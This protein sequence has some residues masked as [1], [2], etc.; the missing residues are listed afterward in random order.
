MN[1]LKVFTNE[2]FGD[3]A[4]ISIDN[5]PYFE[6]I[7]VARILG[8]KNPNDAIKRHC[9]YP[10]IVFHD[11]RVQTGRRRD[12]T[13]SFQ[14]VQRAFISE[15]NLYRLIVKS[16]KEEAE[17]FESWVMDEVLPSIRN[18]GGYVNDANYMIINEVQAENYIYYKLK[19]GNKLLGCIICSNNSEGY[20]QDDL[21]ILELI[22]KQIVLGMQLYKYNQ[23]E[24]KH[25][26]IAN[27]L[28]I[29]NKQQK[30]IMNESEMNLE[31]NK[32]LYF[33]HRCATVIGGDFYHAQPID[34][35]KV[36]YIIADVMGHGIVS[37]YIVAMIKGCFKTLCYNYQ[38]AADIM[39]KLNQI[40]YDE[41]DKMD[42]FTT[43]IVSIVDTQ[44]NTLDISNAG[45]YCPIIIDDTGNIS[46]ENN[47]CKKNIP[48]GV[49]EDTKYEHSTISIKS[50]AMICMYTDGI[51]EL[52]NQHKEEFGIERLEQFLLKNYKL[53]KDDFIA[54]LKKELNE[55]AAKHNFDDDILVVC[56]SN[57]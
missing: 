55:F 12:G 3:V 43:C 36:A 18:D 15:G 17:K 28:N 26:L 54:E 24:T 1:G 19:E 48:L 6:G 20:T 44:N 7:K 11:T 8:Y 42:V 27:E 21:N 45:H 57:K 16:K 23:S 50:S 52:K 31:N 25:K 34:E 9:K 56:L 30:L 29:L 22:S 5:K 51:I 38:T 39:N 41:F 32:D 37:N 13:E 4:V 47:L 46:T 40:L 14:I 35:N 53:K 33:Y 10:G 49:L 2:D